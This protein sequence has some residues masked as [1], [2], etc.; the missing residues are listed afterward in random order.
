[1]KRLSDYQG[2]A[3]IELW[4]ELLEPIGA[5][6][7]DEEVR[8]A[9]SEKGT[10]TMHKVQAILKTHK[11]DAS[12][13]LLTIDPTPLT[14]LNII[15]RLLDLVLEVENSEEFAGFFGSVQQRTEEE[16]SG[17]VTANTGAI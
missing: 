13:I 4:A 5:V 12:K 16:S 9:L 7:Q 17:S 8:N 2:E 11:A 15:A 3:A 14:G 1:M 10:S 6:L